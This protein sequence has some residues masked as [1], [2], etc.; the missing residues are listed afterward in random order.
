MI[1]VALTDGCWQEIL[2]T[3]YRR[4]KHEERKGG[5]TENEMK[6]VLG[7]GRESQRDFACLSIQL[8]C[9]YFL[10]M[11]VVDFSTFLFASRPAKEIILLYWPRGFIGY[12][13]S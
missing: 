8:V 9:L 7:R 4:K 1:R 5:A 10:S 13:Q 3:L 11:V 12:Q 6:K 2:T